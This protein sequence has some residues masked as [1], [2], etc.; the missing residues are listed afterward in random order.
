MSDVANGSPTRIFSSGMVNDSGAELGPPALYPRNWPFLRRSSP[1]WTVGTPS[2]RPPSSPPPPPPPPQRRGTERVRNTC[3]SV[4]LSGRPTERASDAA[5]GGRD[6]GVHRRGERGSRGGG[7][8]RPVGRSLA[9][10]LSSPAPNAVHE[11]VKLSNLS[12]LLV[13][14]VRGLMKYMILHIN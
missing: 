12:S 11:H 1:S 5:W 3:A 10:S 4:R 9:Q 6:W 14:M 7:R 2:F 13:Q 8:V